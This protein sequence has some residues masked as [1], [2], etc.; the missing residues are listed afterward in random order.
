VE[1]YR[2]PSFPAVLERLRD[3]PTVETDVVFSRTDESHLP[4]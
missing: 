4:F 1:V 2:N 3:R